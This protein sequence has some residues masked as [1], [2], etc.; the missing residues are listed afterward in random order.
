MRR[1]KQLTKADRLKIEALVKIGHTAREIADQIGV[2]IS[3]IYRELKRG[4]YSHTNTDLTEEERYSPDIAEERYQAN[5]RA[6]GPALKIGSDYELA[7]YIEYK[8]AE[9][10]YSP[11]ATLAEINERGLKFKT[12]ISKQTLYSYI[13]KGIFLTL[14]NKNLPVKR[15]RKKHNKKVQ[16]QARAVAGTSI[17]KRPEDILL[18]EEFG[19]WEMDTVVGKRGVS[20]HSMLV[21]TERKT[22]QEI[23][24]LLVEHTTEKVVAALDKLEQKWGAMFQRVFKSITVDNGSEFADNDGMKK[25]VFSDDKRTDIYYCHPYSSYERGS[26]ENQNKLIRRWIPKGTNFDD[27]TDE[28]IQMIEDWINNYPR[29][30]HGWKSSDTMFQREIRKLGC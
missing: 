19:H 10:G 4:K 15:N 13:D 3:T 5:L 22:R 20:K 23:I 18:R 6:K 12:S 27:K 21:L 30:I 8:I 7:E 16:R 2:H 14:T 26:N 25:S 1:F 28:D 17:E 29:E 24:M 9:E 11:A